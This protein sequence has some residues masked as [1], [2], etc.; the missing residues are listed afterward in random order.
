MDGTAV[1]EELLR[2]LTTENRFA[3]V[4]DCMDA[5]EKIE[6]GLVWFYSVQRRAAVEDAVSDLLAGWC[7]L[8][9]DGIALSFETKNGNFR[10]PEKPE[11]EKT[12]KG[13]K[14]AFTE[15]FR[16]NTALLRRRIRTPDLKCRE[17]V[18]G[19]RTRSKTGLLYIEGIVNPAYVEELERRLSEIDIDGVLNSGELEE[20]I[21]ERPS[22]FPQMLV[23][24]RPDRFAGELLEGRVGLIVEGLPLG[25]VLPATFAEML[26]APDDLS[27]HFVIASALTLLRYISLFIS[28]LLPAVYVAITMYHHEMIPTK[29]MLSMIEAKQNVPFSTAAEILGM[30][31]S[32]ELLQEAGLRLPDSIGQTVSI[33]GGLIVGQSAVEA[34]VIS[35]IV[36][37]VVAL[38]GI[39]GY[40]VP[41]QD[42]AAALRLCRMAMV[43]LSLVLGLF[44]IFMGILLLL[45]Y[46]CTLENFGVAYMEPFCSGNVRELLSV[47]LRPPI[48][49]R[50]YRLRWLR[51]RDKRRQK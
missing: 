50:K 16:T 34:S 32:F 46:L 39:T 20:F 28:V 35:P 41:N 40:T 31:I 38:A 15:S 17:R 26:R 8:V 29:L 10:K 21:P 25:F 30:L 49:L 3:S 19:R 44:G 43:L 13:A 36:V 5:A 24:E 48:R 23:T 33:I 42:M 47:V 45:Y 37:I 12:V 11:T 6:T 4:T 18:L 27:G 1:G 51:P 9:F 7:I 14:E 2:P 22:P